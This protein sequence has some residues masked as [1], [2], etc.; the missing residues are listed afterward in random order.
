MPEQNG[1]DSQFQNQNAGNGWS[2]LIREDGG[3]L[4]WNT[5][6][7]EWDDGKKNKRRFDLLGSTY[8]DSIWNTNLDWN[9]KWKDIPKTYPW[10]KWRNAR[11]IVLIVDVV[12]SMLWFLTYWLEI[13]STILMVVFLVLWIKTIRTP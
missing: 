8:E 3:L 4:N 13:L 7:E 9:E 12:L 6:S 11:A 5:V 1:Q 10:K 2:D